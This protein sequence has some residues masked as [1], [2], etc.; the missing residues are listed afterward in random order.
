MDTKR[1]A[2]LSEQGL[3]KFMETTSVTVALLPQKVAPVKV[4][5][6]WSV[7]LICVSEF[8]YIIFQTLKGTYY[9]N[10]N[11]VLFGFSTSLPTKITL[12]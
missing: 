4:S 10:K 2:L 6:V 12:K 3:I 8:H 5:C 1:I 11:T 9:E 7:P